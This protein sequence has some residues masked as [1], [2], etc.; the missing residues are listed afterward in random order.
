M[1]AMFRQDIYGVIQGRSRFDFALL[2][3]LGIQLLSIASFQFQIKLLK[4]YRRAKANRSYEDISDVLSEIKI[5]KRLWVLNLTFASGMIIL[6][7]Y[8]LMR[9]TN[10]S[11]WRGSLFIS[12]F[13][14]IGIILIIE[15]W[16]AKKVIKRF[17]ELALEDFVG[18]FGRRDEEEVL[19]EDFNLKL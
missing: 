10:G 16:Y 3:P 1:Y 9:W 7:T 19:E 15:Q 18:D 2:I 6:A 17:S 13:Y 14:L 4:L 12:G 11:D 8:I 5:G